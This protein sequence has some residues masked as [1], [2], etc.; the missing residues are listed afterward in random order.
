M[1]RRDMTEREALLL[2]KMWP[3]P[4]AFPVA[5]IAHVLHC[6]TKTLAR[7]VR[8]SGLPLRKPHRTKTFPLPRCGECGRRMVSHRSARCRVCYER[9]GPRPT[10]ACPD[11]GG[12][13]VS[14]L[15]HPRCQEAA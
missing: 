12:R 10:Y 11:C 6:S 4:E 3:L 9:G 7:F 13:A 14:P 15:G 5:A 8:E 1:K 2:R